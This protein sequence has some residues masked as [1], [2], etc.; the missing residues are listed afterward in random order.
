M[1]WE[2]ERLK[3][4]QRETVTM[5]PNKTQGV[6]PGQTIIVDLPSS[7]YVATIRRRFFP[8]VFTA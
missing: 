4:L 7:I 3:V 6:R 1:Q 2:I 8:D 5:T